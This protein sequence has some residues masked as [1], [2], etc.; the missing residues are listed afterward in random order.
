[1][2]KEFEKEEIRVYIKYCNS[3]NVYYFANKKFLLVEHLRI[4]FKLN[5]MKRRITNF[6][7]IKIFLSKFGK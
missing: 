1:M 3:Q 6:E 5:F 2:G 7:K 4:I